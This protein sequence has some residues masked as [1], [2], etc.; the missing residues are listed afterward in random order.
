LWDVNEKRR[1]EQVGFCFHY[2]GEVTYIVYL[3][4]LIINLSFLKVVAKEEQAVLKKKL[5]NYEKVK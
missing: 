1:V 4:Q 2:G 3:A 5:A